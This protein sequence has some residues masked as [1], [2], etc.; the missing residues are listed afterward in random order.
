MCFSFLDLSMVW[1]GNCL[2]DRV[3]VQSQHKV[4]YT[5]Y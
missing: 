1:Y 3:S 4:I 2:W 5:V